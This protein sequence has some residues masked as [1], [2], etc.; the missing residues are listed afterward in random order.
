[1]L[2]SLDGE[3]GTKNT[4]QDVRMLTSLDDL[5]VY[6]NYLGSKYPIISEEKVLSRPGCSKDIAN[7]ILDSFPGI[8]D[9]YV[10]IV[11]EINVFG[12]SIGSFVLSPQSFDGANICE[13]LIDCNTNSGMSQYFARDKVYQIGS[14]EADPVAIAATSSKYVEGS[15]VLYDLGNPVEEPKEIALDY[16]Q[17]LLLAGNVDQLRDGSSDKDDKQKAFQDLEFVLDKFGLSEASKSEW[18]QIAEIEF[19]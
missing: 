17:F 11:S 6:T 9:L 8:S 19:S 15:V 4:R 14:F 10:E 12:V 18:R 13:K 2:V 16:K 3:F 5:V 7:D 1:M